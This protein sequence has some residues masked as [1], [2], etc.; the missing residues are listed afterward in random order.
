MENVSPS[1]KT[2]RVGVVILTAL[3]VFM[4]GWIV[5]TAVTGLEWATVQ[6]GQAERFV[7]RVADNPLEKAR[8]LAGTE[9]SDLGDA[10]GMLFVYD[11]AEP[12]VFTMKG[13]RYNLDILWIRDGQVIKV[14]YNVPAPVGDAEPITLNTDPLMVDMVLEMPAGTAQRVNY[15]LGHELTID[16][17]PQ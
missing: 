1:Q 9:A 4:V 17:D 15:V 7:V 2:S 11:K 16:L 8:G 3:A 6:Q 13:M 12:R 14:D 5:L 10:I